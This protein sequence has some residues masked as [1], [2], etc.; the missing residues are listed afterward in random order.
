MSNY[1]LTGTKR[2]ILGKKTKIVRASGNI[3]ATIYGKNVTPIS[4]SVS[5]H[6]FT[7]LYVEAGE[8]GLITLSIDGE[9]HPVL[10]HT[11]QLD[12]MK[13]TYLHIEFH[14]VNLKEKVHA[15][16]PIE[17]V[18]ESQAVKDK[19]GMFMSLL[20]NIE[21][22]ALPNKLPE[23]ISIDV[24]HLAAINEQIVVGD[25]EPME[26]VTILT[27]PTIIIAKIGSFVVEKEPEPTPT[28]EVTP[29]VGEQPTE[30]SAAKP[31]ESAPEE[32]K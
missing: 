15:D 23:K 25:I 28:A 30:E 32:K 17:F 22:E 12:P 18:G 5:M 20:N 14:E 7:K 6:D 4:C 16:I 21:V 27:D 2:T 11:V 9:T 29:E 31:E 1:S 8:T 24:S 19:V 13:G 3:P 26:D 10:I